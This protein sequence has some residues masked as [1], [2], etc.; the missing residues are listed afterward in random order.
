MIDKD[1]TIKIAVCDD[2]ENEQNTI[3][4]LI[5]QRFAQTNYLE[6]IDQFFCGE[7]FLASDINKYDLVFMDIY[8]SG[9]NGM[10]VAKQLYRDNKHTKIVFCTT[11]SDFGVE[12]YDVEA[13][14]YLLKPIDEK[15]FFAVLD[16]FFKNFAPKKVITITC[17]RIDETIIVDDILWIE[18]QGHKSI[19]HTKNR[20]YAT[21]S[22]MSKIKDELEDYGFIKPVRYALVSVN[23]IVNTPNKSITLT[24]GTEIPIPKDKRVSVRKD[25]MDAKYKKLV[26]NLGSD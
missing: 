13:M 15:R 8:M 3:I 17:D 7:D 2:D 20:D 24:D 16:F 14:R 12:S 4:N 5:S 9:I 18:A 10:E 11:S 26:E 1:F 23:S 21:R 25:F 6:D 19:I 22:P